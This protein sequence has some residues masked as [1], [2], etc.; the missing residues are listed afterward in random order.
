MAD[1]IEYQKQQIE[2]LQKRV[3]ELEELLKLNK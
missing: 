3:A 1:L 2:A